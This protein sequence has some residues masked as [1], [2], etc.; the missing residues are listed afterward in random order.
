MLDSPAL[1]SPAVLDGD[2]LRARIRTTRR[3]QNLRAAL[4]VAPL[5]FYLCFFFFYPVASMLMR[6][7]SNEEFTEA[8]PR[9]TAAIRG[10]SGNGLPGEKVYEA[11][12]ADTRHLAGDRKLLGR[13]ARRLNFEIAGF[14][15]LVLALPR[16]PKDIG[17]QSSVKN[18]MISHDARWGDRSYWA[19]VQ[20][21]STPLTDYYALQSVDLQ[22]D[23]DNKIRATPEGEAI[24][25]DV[26]G[27]TIWISLQVVFCC[28]LVGYPFTLFLAGLS[29]GQR[30]ALMFFVLLPFWTALLARTTAWIV[31]LQ[32][33]G[34]VNELLQFMGLTHEPLQ[35][36]FNRAGVVIVMT[37][38]LLPFF[39]L[40]LYSVM[41]SINPQFM[42][43]ARSLG[44]HPFEAFLRVYLPL[45]MPGVAAGSLLVFIISLGFYVTPA[46]VGGS[47]DQLI[48]T[49]I[50]RYVDESLNWGQASALAALLLLFV[51][52]FYLIYH[53]LTG[54]RQIH[55]G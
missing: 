46:L 47:R 13:A 12:I 40:P 23:V 5:F 10:W 34:L 26:Y 36:I 16:L 7:V 8:F 49:F 30:N 28:L 54:G 4:L 18:A 37:H 14:R 1:Q 51:L 39:I 55:I 11:V 52:V 22:R 2:R 43:A 45:S 3:R 33:E 15:S 9:T 32:R 24:F 25:L 6:S 19:V 31:L 44:A 38:V 35:L 41:R 21:A 48:S 50:A 42:R 20:R 53:R 17:E 27:R 29:G